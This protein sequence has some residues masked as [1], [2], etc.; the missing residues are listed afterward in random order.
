[1]PDL[2]KKE[3][4]YFISF[5]IAALG[6]IIMTLILWGQTQES[7]WHKYK[8]EQTAIENCEGEKGNE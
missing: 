2:T 3:S 5:A 6:I 4:A 1:M 7:C 8:T